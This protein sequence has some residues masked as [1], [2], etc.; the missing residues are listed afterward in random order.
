MNITICTTRPVSRGFLIVLT[1]LLS[2]AVCEVMAQ[3]TCP[4]GSYRWPVVPGGEEQR[5]INSTFMEYRPGHFHDGIDIHCPENSSVITCS[6]NMV[7]FRINDGIYVRQGVEYPDSSVYVREIDSPFETFLYDHLKSVAPGLD[8]GDVLLE[9]GNEIG[10]TNIRNHLHFN[11]GPDSMEIN[12]LITEER[13]CHFSDTK[14]PAIHGYRIEKDGGDEVLPK[15]ENMYYVTGQ[16][17]FLVWSSDTV[18][19]LGGNN[20]GLF[21]I[22]Y[23]VRD[24]NA[25]VIGS[26][27][28]FFGTN[29]ISSEN[30][31]FSRIC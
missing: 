1:I 9:V 7:V 22:E 27:G 21:G 14:K 24:S 25:N 16:I 18:S 5:S 2:G 13:L 12:P 11:E 31:F 23:T 6:D 26:N 8:S 20:V 4:A 19:G 29:W 15:K 17:D 3:T 30:W 28:M 10:K